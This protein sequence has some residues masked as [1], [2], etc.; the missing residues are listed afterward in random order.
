MR[1]LD[2][3]N[4]VSMNNYALSLTTTFLESIVPIVD[5][6]RPYQDLQLPIDCFLFTRTEVLY[7]LQ[8]TLEELK[9]KFKCSSNA[10]LFSKLGIQ[11]VFFSV[12]QK[13]CL[14]LKKKFPWIPNVSNQ[15]YFTL[16]SQGFGSQDQNQN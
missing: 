14:K 11:F 8:S 3:F 10:E 12:K 7:F 6:S 1:V 9:N 16:S 2:K 15:F 13:A 5:Q 4:F